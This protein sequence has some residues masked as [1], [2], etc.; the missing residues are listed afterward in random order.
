MAICRA[1]LTLQ[2]KTQDWQLSR[3]MRLHTFALACKQVA[4]AQNS[5]PHV[6]LVRHTWS[7][8]VSIMSLRNFCAV[9]WP[10]FLGQGSKLPWQAH[11]SKTSRKIQA[12]GLQTKL[13]CAH[14]LFYSSIAVCLN[15]LA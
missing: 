2:F 9:C 5:A 4:A 7:L 14:C 13:Q 6:V 11:C 10:Y 1:F 3:S 15:V 12:E 8:A